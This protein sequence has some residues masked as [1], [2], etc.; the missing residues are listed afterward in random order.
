[1]RWL[2]PE[3]KLQQFLTQLYHL[4]A[5]EK[6]K[7]VMAIALLVGRDAEASKQFDWF[8]RDW[9]KSLLAL[10]PDLD[11]RVWPEVGDVNDIDFALAWQPPF[12]ALKKFPKLKAIGSLGAGVDHLFADPDLPKHIPMVRV[13]DPYMA[14]DI[15]QYVTVCV[16]DYVKRMKFWQQKQ[17]EKIWCKQP[18]FNYADKTVAV[19][20]VGFLG[21]KLLE[22][23]KQLGL[24]VIAWSLTDKQIPGVKHYA[25]QEQFH[26]FLSHADILICII[27]LT[28]ITKNILNKETFSHLPDGA[29][30]INVG[31]GEHLVEEDLIAAL[32]TGKLVGAALDVFKTEPLPSSHSFWS[33]EK[34][35]VTPHI[36]SV[37]NPPTVAPQM[38]DNYQRL[39]AGKELVNQVDMERGY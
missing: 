38:L 27:P 30:L 15:V 8:I 35:V 12:G 18:P 32:A 16:L 2:S 33:N 37:T 6:R 36:A 28:P 26:E 21:S 5:L 23:L 24:N 7:Y 14:N 31:R 13:V 11:V 19:M 22:V 17:K 9:Q 20:G 1:M 34:I 3:F 39:L 4:P 10:Q 29:Y 25:G